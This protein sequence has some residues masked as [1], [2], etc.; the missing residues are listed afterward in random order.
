MCWMHKLINSTCCIFKIAYHQGP[1]FV[2]TDKYEVESVN[3]VY[4]SN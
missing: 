2:W 1:D 4:F 3:Y